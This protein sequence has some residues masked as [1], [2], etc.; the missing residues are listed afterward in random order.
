MRQIDEPHAPSAGNRVCS[1]FGV[2]RNTDHY[3]L[4][5]SASIYG[6]NAVT[7][8]KRSSDTAAISPTNHFR[9]TVGVGF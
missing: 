9:S 4:P 2:V 7:R 1:G 5:A 6:D 3:D 8:P